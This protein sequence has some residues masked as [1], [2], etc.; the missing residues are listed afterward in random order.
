MRGMANSTW[1][2]EQFDCPGCGID[3]TAT[4]EEQS[5]RRSG[6]FRCGVCDT[7]VHRWSGYQNFFD[8]KALKM[9]SSFGRK[10]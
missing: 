10:R 3:Y 6:N 1:T 7:E 4:C 9:M 2:I 5:N 8:W